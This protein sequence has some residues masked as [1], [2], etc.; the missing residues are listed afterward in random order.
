[1]RSFHH[2]LTLPYFP[3]PR[4][5][6]SLD[7]VGGTATT[8]STPPRPV[9]RN[10]R[11]DSPVATSRLS[12]VDGESAAPSTT[13]SAYATPTKGIAVGAKMMSPSSFNGTPIQVCPF[14]CPCPDL[15][16]SQIRIYI[17][18]RSGSIYV[19]DPDLSPYSVPDLV[20][21]F[22]PVQ[23]SLTCVPHPIPRSQRAGSTAHP[24][25]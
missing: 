22:L 18:H 7:G 13:A 12:D 6:R 9:Q 5:R 1:M 19:T 3:L 16:M 14:R 25:P 2:L 20:Y 4:T 11:Q 24:H 21:A 17:R 10:L 8:A 23:L 15:Y